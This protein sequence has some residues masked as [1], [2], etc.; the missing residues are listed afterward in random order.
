MRV[1]GNV[2]VRRVRVNVS[3]KIWVGGKIGIKV[4]V[5]VSVKVGV[6]VRRKVRGRVSVKVGVGV[7]VRAIWISA[8]LT[9]SRGSSW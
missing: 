9:K 5:R 7:D 1:R 3:I 8:S 2:S 6:G 4:S